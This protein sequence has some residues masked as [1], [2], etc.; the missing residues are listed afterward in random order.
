MQRFQAWLTTGCM[1]PHG[2]VFDVGNATRA[3]ID[4]FTQ[5]LPQEAW[6]GR[7][8]RDNGNGIADADRAA[9]LRGAPPRQPG[10]RG[11]QRRGQRPDARPPAL[12]DVLYVLEGL[13]EAMQAAAGE[14]PA[15]HGAGF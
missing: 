8:E 7:E 5:G 10:D 4:R 6:G 15:R 9:E 3:A 13:D 12:D 11:A 1:T 14:L 2:E